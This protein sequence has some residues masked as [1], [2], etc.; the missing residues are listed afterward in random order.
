[1]ISQHSL[2][3][4]EPSY[5]DRGTNNDDIISSSSSTAVSEEQEEIKSSVSSVN[6]MRMNN[7]DDDDDTTSLSVRYKYHLT[8]SQQIS[9]VMKEILN[10]T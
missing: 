3:N 9:E 2:S 1:M 10:G 8:T 6:S 4:R 7:A 5:R